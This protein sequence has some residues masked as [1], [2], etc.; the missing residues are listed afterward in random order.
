ML[1]SNYGDNLW[2]EFQAGKWSRCRHID[3]LSLPLSTL[4]ILPNPTILQPVKVIDY[5]C[6]D[7]K[8]DGE[9]RKATLVQSNNS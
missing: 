4:E 2:V 5:R 3:S 8:K 1:L 7:G 6:G 9:L